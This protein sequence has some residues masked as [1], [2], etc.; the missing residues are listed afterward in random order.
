MRCFPYL[1]DDPFIEMHKTTL[2]KGAA[3]RKNKG[4]P[5]IMLPQF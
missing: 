1:K 5:V 3:V 4:L 2:E